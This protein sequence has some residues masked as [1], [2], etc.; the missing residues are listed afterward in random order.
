MTRGVIV[1]MASQNRSLYRNIRIFDAK[2]GEEV[3]GTFQNGS[4]TE[5]NLLWALRN[6]IIVAEDVWALKDTASGQ[7]ITDTTNPISPGN[8]EIHSRGMCSH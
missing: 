5:E 1:E 6:V 8:Y 2:T 4:I 3:A 7:T